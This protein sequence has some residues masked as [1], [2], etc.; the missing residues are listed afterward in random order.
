MLKVVGASWEQTRLTSILLFI[1]VVIALVTILFFEVPITPDDGIYSATA[2]YSK[3]TGFNIKFWGQN[4]RPHKVNKGIVRAYYKPTTH[5]TGWASIEIETQS[6]YPDWAQAFGAGLLEGSLSWQ[7]IY[8]RWMN[9]IGTKCQ[10]NQKECNSIRA[11][12]RDMETSVKASARK[13]D[14]TDYYWHQVNLYYTQLDGLEEGWKLGV[15]RSRKQKQLNI[16]HE[17]FLWMNSVEDIKHLEE[18][19]YYNI[20][21]FR[22]SKQ[23]VSLALL[24]LLPNSTVQFMLAHE[25]G[26]PYTEMLR[27]QKKYTFGY[28]YTSSNKSQLVPGQTIIFTSYPGTIYSLDDFYQVSGENALTISGTAMKMS[29]YSVLEKMDFNKI[30][31]G[32][33]VMAACRLSRGGKDWTELINREE[34]GTGSKQWLVV[35]AKEPLSFWVIEQGPGITVGSEETELLENQGYWLA[36]GNPYFEKTRSVLGYNDISKTRFGAALDLLKTGLENV[37]DPSELLQLMHKP[38]LVALGRP[39]IIKYNNEY[40]EKTFNPSNGGVIDLKIAIG[41][42]DYLATAGPLHSDEVPPFQWSNSILQY[43]PHYGQP[44]VWKFEPMR[45]P[46]V[47]E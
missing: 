4:N 25:S 11:K 32:P 46:W 23:Y 13:A 31:I 3:K 36:T 30:L 40:Q 47:W 24:K 10:N 44:D 20:E 6:K 17:D 22:N 21:E 29:N 14:S 37:S 38:E 43:L 7:L 5:Q 9:I 1:V 2:F 45:P 39:D 41:N 33:R 27:M 8:S 19:K 42:N 18:L 34:S 15:S 26:G 35:E 28:H 12:L 16:L